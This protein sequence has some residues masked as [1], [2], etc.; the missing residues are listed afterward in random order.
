MKL[1]LFSVWMISS[2][3]LS[4]LSI[5]V[6]QAE[7]VPDET[8]P[9]AS[10]VEAG[11][12]IC[13]IDRGTTQGNNLFHS[14]RKFSVPTQGEAFF[15]NAANVENILTRV[16]GDSVSNIDGLLRTNGTA[17]LFLL[18]P[19]GVVFGP[20]ARLDVGGSFLASTADAIAFGNQG[21]FSATNPE[22]PVLLTVQP[23]AFLFNHVAHAAIVNRSTTPLETGQE[24]P[25]A[26]R[27]GL[28]VPDGRSLLL[29]GGDI[30]FVGGG[31]NAAGGRVE[32]A[33]VAGTGTV[34]L[35]LED[36]NLR[37]SFPT[38]IDRADI[39]LTDGATVNASG[40]GGGLIQ[41]WGRRV[42][43]NGG[44]QVATSTLGAEPGGRLTVNASESLDAIGGVAYGN[45]STVTFGDGKAGDLLIETRRLSLRDGGTIFS[46]T[47][48]NGSA[49]QL[50]VNAAELV[51]V[52][53]RN[54]AGF[55]SGLVSLTGSAGQGAN[56]TINTRRL[57]VQDGGILS[58]EAADASQD[59]QVFSVSGD[60]ANL[61]INASESVELSRQGAIL[62]T[63]GGPGNGGNVTI[64]TGRLLVQDESAIGAPANDRPSG[65]AGNIVVR[66][67][68]ITLRNQSG[69]DATTTE[70]QGGNIT[71]QV[72]DLLLLQQR[73]SI[74]TT[75]GTNQTGGD[76]G[77][78]TVDGTFI[79]ASP[80]ENSDISADA[81]TGKGGRVEITAQGILGIQARSQSTSLSDI[82]ASSEFGTAGTILLNAPD[83]DP[84]R[85][86][87]ELPA[88]VTDASTLIAI[89]CSPTTAAQTSQGEFYRTGRGGIAP[90]PTD[91]LGSSDIL[92]DLHPPQSWSETAASNAPIEEAQGWQVNDRGEVVL[93]AQ[94]PIQ[95]RQCER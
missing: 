86:L 14:F 66:A 52:A 8:L 6:A 69:I 35:T 5:G 29:L 31:V 68:S 40:E 70:N 62:A 23:S 3:T 25:M 93:L 90:L 94:M 84:S 30:N 53:G 81:F 74:S 48:G 59:G 41:I 10:V 18:N 55:S 75:A 4:G 49:G 1:P 45:L 51:E 54:S 58:A 27:Q 32:L 21:F 17:N 92:E 91:V 95:Q 76:G 87:A 33:A 34:G 61:T 47:F 88:D 50:T 22:A 2:I 28:Q 67:Q 15:N 12:T 26:N 16:T 57:I 46:A 39:S 77:N 73:S 65:N 85:G 11:C 19:N 24:L 60:G 42:F 78:I 63:T 9:N 44:S 56:L 64:N 7:I 38:A 43:M 79:V 89:G 80:N 72:Q 37:L 13:T 36:N 82:T 83:V 20:D 71:L